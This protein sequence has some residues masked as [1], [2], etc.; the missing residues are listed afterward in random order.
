[1][2]VA[3]KPGGLPGVNTVWAIVYLKD[4]PYVVAIMENYGLEEDAASAMKDISQT[5]YEYFSRLAKA[6]PLGTYVDKP[7]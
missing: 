6:T 2:A 5:L 7:K 1:V 3:F 4:R